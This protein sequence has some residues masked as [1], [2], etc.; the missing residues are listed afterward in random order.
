MTLY[1]CCTHPCTPVLG[2]DPNPERSCHHATLFR[3]RSHTLL[4]LPI[5]RTR[6]MMMWQLARNHIAEQVR[7]AAIAWAVGACHVGPRA[8][9][10]HHGALQ[11]QVSAPV[12]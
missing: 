8:H 12:V 2:C 11:Q 4:V 6:E 5:S 1:L 9:Q 7:K 10:Q 3:D